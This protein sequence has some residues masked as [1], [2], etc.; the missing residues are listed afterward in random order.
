MRILVIDNYDSFTHN[1]VQ[2]LGEL[3]AEPVVFRNDEL[4]LEQVGKLAPSGI[5]ISPGPGHPEDK[6]YFGICADVL[7]EVSPRVPTL[8][9][10]LGH[11]GIG[12]VFG[13]R[14]VGA[15]ELRHGKTSRI[16]HDGKGVFR[17]LPNGFRAARY[18]SLVLQRSSL[19]KELE[20]SAESE[21][22]EVMGVRHRHF[23]IEGIQFHPESV[24]TEHGKRIL[25]NFLEEVER[26]QRQTCEA[27]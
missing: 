6:K 26:W 10:C 24:L 27:R 8:G 19:P 20:L 2:Y 22:G 4:T 1:L 3:G 12:L 9:V 21:D 7:Q 13:G 17:G 25:A 14:V 15:R 11:Q 18:H 16:Y 23:P 5:V